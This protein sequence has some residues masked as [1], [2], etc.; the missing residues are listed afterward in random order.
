MIQIEFNYNQQKISIQVQPDDIFKNAINSYIQRT[1]LNPDSVYF[2]SND[3]QINPEQTVESQMN[4]I[5]RQN[6]KIEVTVVPRNKPLEN[7]YFLRKEGEL[8]I[9]L[10]PSNTIIIGNSQNEESEK[11]ECINLSKQIN[12]KILLFFGEINSEKN[13]FNK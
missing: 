2:L 1:S 9:Y 7:A 4:E 11:S 3:K 13:Y 5:N 10:F 8:N 6:R 12:R